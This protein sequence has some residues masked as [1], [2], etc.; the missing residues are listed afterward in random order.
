MIVYRCLHSYM[1][2]IEVTKNNEADEYCCRLELEASRT[3]TWCCQCP[4][5]PSL[6][7][8]CP[9]SPT[10]SCLR[11]SRPSP[12]A[13]PTMQPQAFPPPCTPPFAP[14]CRN[15]VLARLPCFPPP[16]HLL[17]ALLVLA[18]VS[19][20]IAAAIKIASLPST[21]CFAREV[22]SACSGR[23]QHHGALAT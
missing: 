7:R 6:L 4:P 13:R 14:S 9:H 11:S 23:G 18:D 10:T 17:P 8:A 5:R 16:S 3:C 21:A 22:M 12:P 15:T 2:Q 20:S 19:S 1:F